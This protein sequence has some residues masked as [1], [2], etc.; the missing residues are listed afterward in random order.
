MDAAWRRLPAMKLRHAAE[1]PA[2]S[3]ASPN[4]LPP[5]ATFSRDTCVCSPDPAES[6]NGL[7]MNVAV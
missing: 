7:L 4:A 3:D 2:S 1:M 5:S 6:A